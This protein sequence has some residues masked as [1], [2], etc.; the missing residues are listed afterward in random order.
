MPPRG[1]AQDN[2]LEEIHRRDR[3]E[4]FAL[5]ALIAKVIGGATTVR[6]D[7]LEAMLSAYK[8]ELTQYNYTPEYRKKLRDRKKVV[9][10]QSTRKK[11]ADEAL[12]KKLEGLTVPDAELPPIK[13]GA[14]RRK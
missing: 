3:A 8:D 5:V 9:V 12:L 13:Q 7:A 6:N 10:A 14:R 1:S 4:R 11:L 2:L